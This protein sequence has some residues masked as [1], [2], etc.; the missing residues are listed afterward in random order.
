MLHDLLAERHFFRVT[1]HAGRHFFQQSFVGAPAPSRV[2]AGRGDAPVILRGRT[3]WS[4]RT[5]LA[6]VGLVV[7]QVTPIAFVRLETEGQRLVQSRADC[8]VI[9]RAPITIA[10]CIVTKISFDEETSFFVDGCVRFWDV[11]CDTGLDTSLDFVA[12]TQSP[13]HECTGS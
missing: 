3:L 8:I 13:S 7:T 1:A 10:L 12:I 9:T 5:A 6:G 2:Q 4:E 11:R